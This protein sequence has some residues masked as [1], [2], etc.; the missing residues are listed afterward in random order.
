M[1]KYLIGFFTIISLSFGLMPLILYLI[2]FSPDWNLP[3]Y[4][5]QNLSYKSNDWANFGS[6]MSGT[7]GAIF[8]F[9]G[10]LAVVWTLI[11]T[12]KASE[13]QIAMIRTE[14]TFSQFNELVKLLTSMLEEKK[15]PTRSHI[16]VNFHQFK[17]EAYSSISL[18]F[19]RF[20]LRQ[21]HMRNENSYNNFE[22]LSTFCKEYIEKIEKDLFFKESHVYS[23]ILDKIIQSDDAITEALIV[24]LSSRLN[25]DYFFF[26]HCQIMS[27]PHSQ[28]MTRLVN[29]GVPLIIPSELS[30]QFQRHFS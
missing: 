17:K 8:S 14:Q 26:L 15:Y 4:L 1:N 2:H 29:C 3:S 24:I 21:P 16:K 9:F 12:H 10:T 19:N 22:L 25:E 7:S 13:K 27:S 20:L 30:T 5:S 6:F 18:S 23:V 28:Q 11:V